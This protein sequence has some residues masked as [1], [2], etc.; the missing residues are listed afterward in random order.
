M[1][2]VTTTD[3]FWSALLECNKIL[4]SPFMTFQV[5]GTYNPWKNNLASLLS[6]ILR[7]QPGK[8][9]GQPR[10]LTKIRQILKL[11]HFYYYKIYLFFN[12][13]NSALWQLSFYVYITPKQKNLNFSY[14]S[15]KMYKVMGFGYFQVLLT[16]F[17]KTERVW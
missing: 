15:L 9:S 2:T 14:W 16:P 7:S 8:T 17:G 10:F 3:G 6:K 11:I 12:I 5:E 4:I 1:V 13:L